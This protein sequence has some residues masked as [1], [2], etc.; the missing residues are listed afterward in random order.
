MKKGTRPTIIKSN[1]PALERLAKRQA[2]RRK[3]LLGSIRLL[4]AG[5]LLAA[6]LFTQAALAKNGLQSNLNR[7]KQELAKQVSDTSAVL[8]GLDV[9][10]PDQANR[11]MSGLTQLSAA[12]GKASTICQNQP[13]PWLGALAGGYRKTLQDC[14]NF[15]GGAAGLKA[16]LDR[17]SQLSEYQIQL[18]RAIEPAWQYQSGADRLDAAKGAAAWRA[19]LEALRSVQSP[20]VVDSSVHQ[21]LLE[22]ADT[23]SRLLGQLNSAAPG[24]SR[25]QT[26]ADLAA[27]YAKLNRAGEAL[28][29]LL[30]AAQQQLS[31]SLNQSGQ[32]APPATRSFPRV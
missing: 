3:L 16:A 28:K 8:S 26:L 32:T 15:G 19:C 14:N 29:E 31:A 2:A 5:S 10:V 20:A 22:A 27:A 21:S 30:Y 7:T 12:A 6:A 9:A 1:R 11:F 18:L 24:S 13:R 25:A 4:F 23:I 17:F